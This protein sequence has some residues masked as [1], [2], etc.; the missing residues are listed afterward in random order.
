MRALELYRSTLQAVRATPERP[1]AMLTVNVFAAD[2]DAQARHHFTSLQQ[3]FLNLRRGRPGRVPPPIDDIESVL[4]PWR[5]RPA[6]SMRCPARSWARPITVEKGLQEFLARTQAGRADDR[7]PLLRSR[8]ALALAR[9]SPRRCAT[10]ST[11]AA[12]RLAHE[13]HPAEAV[14]CG[15]ARPVFGA[16]P[17]VVA[18]LREN[19]HHLRQVHLA[20]IRLVPKR[21]ARDLHVTDERRN[22]RSR[23][24]RS[25]PMIWL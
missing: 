8:R 2:T 1:Y 6:S 14:A 16:D 12:E 15:A 7:R 9:K 11:R 13:R 23:C 10:G 18:G 19:A 20:A 3:A 22:R 5:R 24:V 21:R 17:A 4:V 25:P